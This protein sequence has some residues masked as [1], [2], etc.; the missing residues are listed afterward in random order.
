MHSWKKH[1]HVIAGRRVLSIFFKWNVIIRWFWR[2]PQAK[3]IL[4][5]DFDLQDINLILSALPGEGLGSRSR[6]RSKSSGISL[7]LISACDPSLSCFQTLTLPVLNTSSKGLRLTGAFWPASLSWLWV[8][9]A[10]ASPDVTS[11]LGG[12][13]RRWDGGTDLTPLA[14]RR[15]WRPSHRPLLLQ[16]PT[17]DIIL[18]AEGV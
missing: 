9:D 15:S 8:T 16:L 14:G 4:G 7:G 2:P 13:G 11:R 1:I 17:Q 3:G 10:P 5:L 6:S 12:R 18:P